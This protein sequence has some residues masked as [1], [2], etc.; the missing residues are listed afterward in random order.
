LSLI[1]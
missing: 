1:L